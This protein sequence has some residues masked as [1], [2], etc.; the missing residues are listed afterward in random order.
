MTTIIAYLAPPLLYLSATNKSTV[1][2]ESSVEGGMQPSASSSTVEV[3]EKVILGRHAG[4]RGRMSA[5]AMVVLGLFVLV[6][7]TSTA[8][9]AIK[10]EWEVEQLATDLLKKS[11]AVH[12]VCDN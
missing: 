12:E 3:A 8:L 4:K 1:T 5:M 11:I 7:C 6:A 10:T 2:A 9:D